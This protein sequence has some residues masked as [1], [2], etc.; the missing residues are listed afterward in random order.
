MMFQPIFG[1]R[2]I[3]TFQAYAFNA[4]PFWP[5]ILAILSLVSLTVSG[6]KATII[7]LVTMGGQCMNQPTD[8]HSVVTRCYA[9]TVPMVGH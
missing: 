4:S 1:S 2:R 5:V 3:G 9:Y 6:V 8:A 7:T